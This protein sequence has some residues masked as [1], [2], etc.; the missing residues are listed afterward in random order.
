MSTVD[1]KKKMQSYSC[2]SPDPDCITI[3]KSGS[4]TRSIKGKETETKQELFKTHKI[5]LAEEAD[6]VEVSE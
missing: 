1:I 3:Q 5:G 2:S 6:K 4:C